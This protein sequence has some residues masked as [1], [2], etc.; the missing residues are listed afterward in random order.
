MVS[1]D[2]AKKPE[3]H[4]MNRQLQTEEKIQIWLFGMET[5]QF[6]SCFKDWKGWFEVLSPL[7]LSP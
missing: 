5:R 7:K 3:Q 6:K 1:M 4:K 2:V